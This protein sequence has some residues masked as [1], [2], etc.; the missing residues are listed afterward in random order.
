VSC[1]S[2]SENRVRLSEGIESNETLLSDNFI[3]I[4]D[5]VRSKLIF[6][7]LNARSIVNKLRELE[8]FLLSECPDI[9]GITE[10]WLHSGIE[11]AEISFAGYKLFRRDRNRI[12][13]QR[14]GG[15]ALYIRQDLN[16]V[17]RAEFIVDDTIETLVCSIECDSL[18]KSIIVGIC[19]RPPDCEVVNDNV[20]YERVGELCERNKQ[21][22]LMG[23]FNFPELDWSCSETVDHSHPFVECLDNNFLSQIVDKPSRG[24]NYLDLAIC[25]D[26][27]LIDELTVGEPFESS[28]HQLIMFSLNISKAYKQKKIPVFNYF[29]VDYEQICIAAKNLIWDRTCSDE[30]VDVNEYWNTLV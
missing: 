1:S 20:L 14:G 7:C 11:D 27:N 12:E 22:V 15:V 8:L 21:I 17:C 13:R 9:L 16:P 19:Y 24:T 4:D 29:K 6:V 23:D 28:D 2:I 3:N 30:W 25:S 5:I 26:V 10:T 18:D